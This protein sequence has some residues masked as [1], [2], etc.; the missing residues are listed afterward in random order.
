M[1]YGVTDVVKHLFYNVDTHF[2]FF[3]GGWATQNNHKCSE[4]SDLVFVVRHVQYT[5]H[6]MFNN[7]FLLTA[8]IV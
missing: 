7:I 1:S 4:L 8:W 2:F 3:G 6:D 5:D